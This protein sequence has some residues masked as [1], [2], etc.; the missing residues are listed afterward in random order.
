MVWVIQ[1]ISCTYSTH[2]LIYSLL[3]FVI[4]NYNKLGANSDINL[5][6]KISNS[7]LYIIIKLLLVAGVNSFNIYLI[8]LYTNS[9]NG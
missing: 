7:N 4:N 3:S 6:T 5:L 9:T 8:N 2:E 1:E